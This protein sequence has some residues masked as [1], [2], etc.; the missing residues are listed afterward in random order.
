M[1]NLPE[2]A[3]EIRGLLEEIVAD[4]RSSIRLVPRK[5]L[6]SWFDSGETVRARDVSGT[7]AERH[8]IEAHREALAQLLYEAAMI[9]FWKEQNPYYHRPTEA[10]GTAFDENKSEVSWRSRTSARLQRPIPEPSIAELLR[11]CTI[12]IAST[13]ASALAQASLSLVPQDKT[14]V[15]LAVSVQRSSPRT[16]M[17]FL[18][19]ISAHANPPGIRSDILSCL[20]VSLCYVG[21]ISDAREAH[22]AA[23]AANPLSPLDRFFAL[24]LSCC[25]GDEAGAREEALELDKIIRP[26]DPRLL[27]AAT[28]IRRWARAECPVELESAR[29][30]ASR[31][32]REFS[33]SVQVL[34]Q[35]L[36]S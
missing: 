7:K 27:E 21:R 6:K 20:A 33:P 1:K 35:A 2:I 19:R 14:R 12:G 10:D 23:S 17:R 13:R 30:V 22:R 28:L 29:R 16:A 32:S 34:C 15:Y 24:N 8:L 5:P 25:L 18:G 31:I 26:G 3:P 4:P 11:Q 36:E 9:A